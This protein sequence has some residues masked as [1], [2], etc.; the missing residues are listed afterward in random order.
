MQ[1]VTNLS[2][3]WRRSGSIQKPRMSFRFLGARG[4]LDFKLG[5]L[6]LRLLLGDVAKV[7]AGLG[8]PVGRRLGCSRLEHQLC[9]IGRGVAVL[10]GVDAPEQLRAGIDPFQGVILGFQHEA[11]V[12]RRR[13]L[14]VELVGAALCYAPGFVLVRDGRDGG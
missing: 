5:P 14:D 7:V 12:V 3:D 9:N 13:I 10:R 8:R 6:L 4:E 2:L 1:T 11:R